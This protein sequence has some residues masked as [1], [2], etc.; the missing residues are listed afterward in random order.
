MQA[1]NLKSPPVVE[2]GEQ[3][4]NMSPLSGV[5]QA[6]IVL[7]KRAAPRQRVE[8]TVAIFSGESEIKP[9]E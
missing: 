8:S 2:D 4:T 5:Y 1:T 7:E 6:R 3:S 9:D